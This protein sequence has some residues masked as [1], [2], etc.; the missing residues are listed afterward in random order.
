MQ[1]TTRC[2]ILCRVST[3]H[4]DTGS[5]LEALREFARQQNWII[6]E[7]FIDIASGSGKKAR[8]RFEACMLAASQR[9]FDVL[10]FFS[11]DRMSRE[12][13][14]KTIGYLEQLTAWGVR[15][16]SYTQPFLC[17]NSELANS[18]VLAVLAALAKQQRID[19]VNRTRAGL[20]RLKAKGVR[21]GRPVKAG[22]VSRQTE[23]RRRKRA[24]AL[25]AASR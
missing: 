24:E 12:G 22:A 6:V 2:G 21:L 3:E 8:P 1:L 10:L 17:S 18:I 9:R 7:E 15:W 25:A 5:Q 13:I 11:L 23:W 4:Q 19:I 20:A 14:V 16:H